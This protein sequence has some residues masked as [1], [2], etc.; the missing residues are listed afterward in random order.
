MLLTS[1][2]MSNF[3]PFILAIL[4]IFVIPMMMSR[5]GLS[6]DDLI[7]MIF[8]FGPFKKEYSALDEEKRIRN[9]QNKKTPHL[10]NS[11][12][13]DIIQMVSDLILFSRKN[14]T[15][16]VYP[17][18]IQYGGK[19]GNLAAFV[20][21]KSRVIGINCFGFAGVI[22]HDEASG[23]WR[24]QINGITQ[25][26]PDPEAL[27]KE[28]Y[29]LARTAMNANGM[30]DLPLDIV[31]VFTNNNV[32]LPHNQMNVCTRKDLIGRLAQIVADEKDEFDPNETAKRVNQ[33]V[34]RIKKRK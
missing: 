20:V 10:N 14:N 32:S 29:T 15:G 7:R 25:N 34:V 26:I 5:Y 31:A 1:S 28:Q 17:A 4:L 11:T 12:H 18:T 2:D 19:T 23:C 16:L 13:D 22:T 8:S 33:I 30:M 9:K 21:T 27:N 6:T 3:M 24:Q